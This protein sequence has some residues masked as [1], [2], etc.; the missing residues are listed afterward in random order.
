MPSN[1]FKTEC[2]ANVQNLKYGTVNIKDTA[3]NITESDDLQEFNINSSCY[4]NDKFIG[5]AVAKKT[6]IN[7]LDDGG[8]DLEN[9]DVSLKTGIKIGE[10][11]EY[12]ELGTYIIPKPN[13]DEVSGKTEATGYDYMSKF[14]IPYVDNNTYPIRADDY[15]ENLCTQVGVIL[16]NKDFPNNNYMIKGNP[17][18]NG[19]TCKT[20]LSNIVQLTAGFA[21]IDTDEKLYVKNFDV[22]GEAVDTIDGNNYTEFKPNNVFGPVNSVKIQMNSGVDGEETIKEEEGLTEDTRCQ[23]TIADNYFLTSEEERNLVIDNIYNTLHGLTYLPLEISYY[24]YPWLKLGNKIKVKDKN[25]TEYIT[26]IMEHSF[27]WNGSYSGTIKS[28]ALTKTQSAYKEIMTMQKWKRNTEF[29]VD[30]INGKMTGIIKEQTEIN[31]KLV[32]Y[33]QDLEGFRFKI[34]EAGGINLIKNSTLEDGLNL[35]HTTTGTLTIEKNMDIKE[36]TTSKTAVKI[37]EGS[38]ATEN[39]NIIAGQEYTFSCLIYKTEL[40]NVKVRVITDIIKDYVVE[41]EPKTWQKFT[42]NFNSSVNTVMIEIIADNNFCYISDMIL[43]KGDTALGWQRHA[44]EFRSDTVIINELGITVEN[45]TDNVKHVMTASE[46]KIINTLNGKTTVTFNAD[47][48]IMTS[49]DIQE[50]ATKGKV[51]ETVRDDGTVMVTMDD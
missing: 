12:Q 16:G 42:A 50:K 19:E 28:F 37:I 21:D 6:K 22:T 15:L 31:D 5:T 46:N 47:K 26:Y 40:T 34:E 36:N 2:K 49:V 33:N 23:I 29:A 51:R 41:I 13:V 24:G 9:K 8:Y 7:I 43:N 27:K 14:D 38:I 25:D 30:K 48:T 17:F 45:S 44:G 20:V 32:E 18:T 4:V 11:I 1:E 3:T 35:Y 39:I 10:E